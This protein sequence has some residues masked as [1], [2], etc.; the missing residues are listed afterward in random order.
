VAL[1]E[2][3]TAS[4]ERRWLDEAVELTEQMI[5]QFYDSQDGG[6]FFTPSDH[7]RLIARP[8]EYQD[9]ATPSGNAMAAWAGLL[10]MLLSR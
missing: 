3:Y 1:I 5:G 4:S 7:E 6:F 2:L 8:K 10:K 9:N